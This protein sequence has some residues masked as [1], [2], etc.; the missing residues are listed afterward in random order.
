M[1]RPV[2]IVLASLGLAS[3]GQG[4][5]GAATPAGPARPAP[6]AAEKI[7]LLAALPATLTLQLSAWK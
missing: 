6:T 1:N 4:E 3:C 5:G 2:L 7:A